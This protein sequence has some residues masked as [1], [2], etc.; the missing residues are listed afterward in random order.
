MCGIVGIIPSVEKEK[1]KHALDTIAHRGPDGFGI[2]KED[3]GSIML[4]HRRLAILDLSE[5]GKQPMMLQKYV[6]S[7]NGEIFNFIELKKELEQ[8][9]YQF[10]SESD[11]EVVVAAFDAWGHECLQRFNGMW[12]LAIWN[13]DNKTLF[14]SR[15]RF[16]K[17]PLFY[18]FSNGHFVFASEMKAIAPFLKDINPSSHF[19][20]CR[21]NIF[22][23]EATHKTLIEGISRFPAASYA[24]MTTS[25]TCLNPVVYYKTID[26]VKTVSSNYDEQ[27]E[28]FR[29]IFMDACSIRM[30]SDVPI[31][32]ALSGGLDSSAV[33]STMAY[34][35]KHIK[36]ERVSKDWQH[37]FVAC[38][39]GSFLD[40]RMFAKQVVDHLGIPATYLEIDPVKGIDDLMNDF[41]Y[42]EE[43]Y[44]TSPIPMMRTYSAIREQGVTVSI[45]GHGA[46]EMMSGYGTDMLEAL[47]DAGIQAGQ[48]ADIIDTYRTYRNIPENDWYMKDSWKTYTSTVKSKLP[49][50]VSKLAFYLR[51][52]VNK[53]QPRY[54]AYPQLGHLNNV[55]YDLFHRSVLPTLLRNYD[56]YSMANGV[57]IRM[58]FMDHRLVEFA[59]SIPWSSKIR[60]GYTK[61]IIR[62]ATAPFMPEPINSRKSKIGFNTPIVEWLKGPWKE[63]F[64]DHLASNDFT[65]CNLVDHEYVKQKVNKAI[66]NSAATWTDGE[67]AWNA[68]QPYLWQN[69]FLNRIKRRE[70]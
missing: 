47:L 28:Q 27:V 11:T 21:E 39:K 56:R 68:M 45:D 10:L 31:G 37:A 41:Y 48:I 12:A 40:E 50:T 9:G 22:L 65:Q 53:H 13:R 63:Y 55:L 29:E 24:Y 64:L 67:D 36:R 4:G 17:K 70:C 42:F 18:S 1:F 3:D 61:A 49:G 20:W 5:K 35:D 30:R 62:D 57:E 19:D 60:K 43:L 26:H 14:L 54:R 25:D 33:I 51:A 34:I 32:T 8:K 16:G 66:F 59:F 58:P 15:D 44:I 38:F 46:D 2:W 6:I 69:G 52:A 7:F 23:Y